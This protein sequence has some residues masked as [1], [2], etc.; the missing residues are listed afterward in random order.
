MAKSSWETKQE[1]EQMIA[2]LK[3]LESTF[4]HSNI[5]WKK[6]KSQSADALAVTLSIVKRQVEKGHITL[7]L[8]VESK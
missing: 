4:A 8:T 2:E 6:I 7:K 5:D 1:K 3:Q